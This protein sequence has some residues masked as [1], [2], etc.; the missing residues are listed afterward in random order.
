M[1]ASIKRRQKVSDL[2]RMG[3]SIFGLLSVLWEQKG[4]QE[5][6]LAAKTY[7]DEGKDFTEITWAT[8]EE[9]G[10]IID[11]S[12]PTFIVTISDVVWPSKK[13]EIIFQTKTNEVDG[14]TI[15]SYELDDILGSINDAH[16]F[17]L[18][19]EV[20]GAESNDIHQTLLRTDEQ[21]PVTT[22]PS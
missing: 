14:S 19:G 18:T 13:F 22:V 15:V 10:Q 8:R 12:K 11:Q 7:I 4:T 17:M 1:V 16:H 20:P 2:N 21:G 3:L 5:V 9:D 6:L